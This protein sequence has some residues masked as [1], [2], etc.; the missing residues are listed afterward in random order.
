MD[1]CEFMKWFFLFVFFIGPGLCIFGI[2]ILSAIIDR[3]EKPRSVEQWREDNL[4]AQE[5]MR[6]ETDWYEDKK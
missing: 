5:K 2:C 1:T 6:R 4:A 3:K